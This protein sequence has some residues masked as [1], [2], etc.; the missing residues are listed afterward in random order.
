MPREMTEYSIWRV[1]DR[2]HCVRA[3]QRL[4]ADLGQ[5]DGPHIT[6]LHHFGNRADRFLDRH[7]GVDT[8]GPIHV[9]MV[10]A[11]PPERVGKEVPERL[12]TAVE[13]APVAVGF[14]QPAG[15]DADRHVVAVVGAQRLLG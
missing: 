14:A 2:V 4:D 6:G 1:G 15:L 12:G 8:S 11:Q 13:A 10:R 9:H 3:A 5:A 7:L